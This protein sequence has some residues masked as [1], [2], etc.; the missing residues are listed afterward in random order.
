MRSGDVANA[1]MALGGEVAN[2]ILDTGDV[3]GGDAGDGGVGDDAVNEDRGNSAVE[4]AFEAVEIAEG[5]RDEAVDA[6]GEHDVEV[7]VLLLG[8][9]VGVAEQGEVFEVA[10]P[11]FDGVG[12]VGEERVPDIGKDKTNG[13]GGG[14]AEGACLGVGPEAKLL[15]CIGDCRAG[16]GRGGGVSGE[17]AGGSCY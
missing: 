11:L 14:L 10:C 16:L 2:G 9:F 5:R 7:A 15:G 12:Q 3:V 6:L 13:F 4:D 1:A 8:A 17:H